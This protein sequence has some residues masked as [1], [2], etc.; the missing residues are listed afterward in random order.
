MPSNK[1]SVKINKNLNRQ[2]SII[3]LLEKEKKEDFM[4]KLIKEALKK[5]HDKYNRYK[6]K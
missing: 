6:F 2:L 5:Y 1:T 3:A 4:N